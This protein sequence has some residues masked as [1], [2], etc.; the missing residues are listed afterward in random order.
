MC[1]R[2][3]GS[4]FT[5][6]RRCPRPKRD[7]RRAGHQVSASFG[8]RGLAL[9]WFWIALVSFASFAP[10]T[11]RGA[12]VV[13]VQNG[14]PAGT[15]LNDPTPANPV[16]GNP[17]TTLGEQRLIA[18]QAAANKWGATL[19]S[20]PPI[21]ILVT[22][23]ALGCDANSAA[24]AAA[25]PLTIWR[26]FAG[27]RVSN[28]WYPAALANALLG[29]DLDSAT[30]EIRARFN[31]NLGSTG[32]LTGVQFYLGLDNNANGDVDL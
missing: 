21:T 28:T 32:C 12:A 30:T 5:G 7:P 31:I 29:R 1:G 25:G 13:V 27:A 18:L 19:D 9:L 23:Q 15:G 24:L 17:G 16:G 6:W 20:V 14:D 2:R 4:R 3:R 11:L 22:W 10:S 8:G 26:D